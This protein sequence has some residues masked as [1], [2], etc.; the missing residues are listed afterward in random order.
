MSPQPATYKL[1]YEVGENAASWP[2]STQVHT[3]WTFPSQERAPDPLPPGWTCG[4]KGGGGGGGK[5]GGGGRG[6]GGGG[7]CSFEPLLFTHYSTSA[8]ID[9]V[10]AAGGPA[11]VDVSVSHQRGATATPIATF[12]AQVSYDDGQTWQD[13]SP[14]GEGNG[15]YRLPYPQ[16]ALSPTDGSSALRIQAADDAR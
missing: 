2:E 15:V 6:G 10:V 16:P 7:G 14:T 13:V 3:E 12:T 9:D 4:G 8:G 1:R 11:T 5:G